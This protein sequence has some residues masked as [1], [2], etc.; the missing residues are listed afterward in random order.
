MKELINILVF[1]TIW[2]YGLGKNGTSQPEKNKFPYGIIEFLN[3]GA[4]DG[5]PLMFEIKDL[6]NGYSSPVVSNGRIF[7]TGEKD[8]MGFLYAFDFKGILLWKSAYGE[9]WTTSFPG[10]RAAPSIEGDHIYVCSGMGNIA[11]FKT[12]NGEKVWSK[13]M[14]RDLNGKNP[15]YGYSMPLLTDGD[16]LF[17]SPGGKENNVAALN[18]FS[19]ELIW[20]SGCLGETAGYGAPILIDFPKRKL[21]VT[22][23]EF[24][25]LGLDALTGDLLWSYELAFKGELPCN[26]PVYDDNFLYWIAGPGNGAVKASLPEDGG[27]MEVI[28]K[29]KDFDTFFGGFIKIGNYLYGSSNRYN[30][31]ISVDAGSGQIKKVLRFGKA[32]L[33][34]YGGIIIAYNQRGQTGFIEPN[35][36]DPE[37][38]GSYSIDHGTNEHF[39]YPVVEGGVL[40]IRHGDVLMAYN[41]EAEYSLK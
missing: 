23:S 2:I 22:A 38:I 13:N 8:K 34:E 26:S 16:F 32:S 30:S 40:Y 7:I 33:T 12:E 19:G 15:T 10:S 41:L 29:N 1:A 11:C 28:W 20:K 17:C 3:S 39:S 5:P 36:G 21:L 31:F 24:N 6:G 4:E 18:R 14:I 25:I 35:Q 9:E 27:K 37:L